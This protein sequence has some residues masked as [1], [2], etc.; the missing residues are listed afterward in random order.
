MNKE[1][2]TKLHFNK[3]EVRWLVGVYRASVNG[4]HVDTVR[5]FRSVRMALL[6]LSGFAQ[7]VKGTYGYFSRW[8]TPRV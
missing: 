1:L 8:I 4:T 7:Q 3:W 2:S 5:W 6:L